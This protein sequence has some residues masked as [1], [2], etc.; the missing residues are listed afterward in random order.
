MTIIKSHCASKIFR[1]NII[2]ICDVVLYILYKIVCSLGNV[3]MYLNAIYYHLLNFK[4]NL[5]H[6]LL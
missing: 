3:Y 6:Q 4:I 5:V 1:N 2:C